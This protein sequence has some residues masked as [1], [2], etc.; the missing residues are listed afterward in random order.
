MGSTGKLIVHKIDEF[1]LFEIGLDFTG[2]A[3]K[4]QL[5][6]VIA[7]IEHHIA[8]LMPELVPAIEGI[9]PRVEGATDI[10]LVYETRFGGA[11]MKI[12]F[13]LTLSGIELG[14]DVCREI[15]QQTYVSFHDHALRHLLDPR[16]ETLREEVDE[17]LDSPNF[18]IM[19]GVN[20]LV[21][22]DALKSTMSGCV[23]AVNYIESLPAEPVEATITELLSQAK[24]EITERGVVLSVG[25]NEEVPT[26]LYL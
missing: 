26:G 3:P 13:W 5:D 4:P 10:H 17:S 20:K 25:S 9:A 7:C 16:N 6:E 19:C 24:A 15:I 14:Y 2:E 1:G 12:A 11:T 21:P 18:Q 23:I 22:A 8:G